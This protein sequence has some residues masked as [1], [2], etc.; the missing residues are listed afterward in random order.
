VLKVFKK[1]V[2]A[3]VG[4]YR[5]NVLRRTCNGAVNTFAGEKY[6]AFD[7]VL[8]TQREQRGFAKREVGHVDKLVE[9]RR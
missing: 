5:A 4:Q 7:V 3:Q 2:G 9:G 8:F 6:Q 1:R